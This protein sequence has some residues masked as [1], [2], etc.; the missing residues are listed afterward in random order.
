MGLVFTLC[1]VVVSNRAAGQQSKECPA[2]T[3]YTG[4]TVKSIKVSSPFDFIPAVSHGFGQLAGTLPLKEGSPFNKRAYSEGVGI[5]TTSVLTGYVDGFTAMRFIA[6]VPRL[7]NCTADSVE[8]RY[9][10]YSSVFPPLAGNSFEVRQGEVEKPASTGG[11]LSTRGRFLIVPDGGYNHT[12]RG[13]AGGLIQSETPVSIFDH[14]KVR[15]S[16]SSN[17]LLGSIDLSGKRMLARHY[18]DQAEWHLNSTYRDEPA[19]AFRLKEAKLAASFFGQTKEIAASKPVA[20]YA[21]SLAGGHQQGTSLDSVNSSYGDLKAISGLQWQQGSSALSGSYGLQLG[22]TFNQHSIDFAKHILDLRYSWYFSPLPKYRKP[23]D[24][25]DRPG[26]IGKVHRP[27]SLEGQANAGL[28]QTFGVVPAPERFFGGNQESAPFIENQ[29]WDVRGGPY[30]RSIPEN[31]IGAINPAFGVGGTRFYSLNLTLA[32]AVMG[33]PLLPKE[34]SDQGFVD[35]LDG[36]I[37]TAKLATTNT[38]LAQ[39]PE[40]VKAR[41]VARGAVTALATEV[42][43]LRTALPGFSFGPPVDAKIA[44]TLKDL[45]SKSMSAILITDV[46][47]NGNG[48]RIAYLMDTLTPALLADLD[49]V[50]AALTAP[51]LAATA[52]NVHALRNSLQTALDELRK[53]WVPPGAA[54]RERAKVQANQDMATAEK[55]LNA[56]LYQ[57]NIYSVAPVGVFDVARVWPSGVGVRYGIGGGVRVS[58]VNANFTVG[59]AANPVRSN[60]EGP[61]ALFFKLDVLELFH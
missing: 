2:D 27:F 13:Y 33:K 39:D 14:I 37:A 43:K 24:F 50:E 7:E 6:T 55:V 17:S 8:V 42:G 26:F 22:S 25:D 53:D 19:G 4:R 61:G 16:A 10:V 49:K 1:I 9:V 52:G 51:E 20:H 15:S 31:Q 3:D 48:T 45:K 47:L 29:P 34:L 36:G 5:I 44:G 54:A 60:K 35:A 41:D 57:L 46:V 32:K 38:Y 30:I 18:L 56:L 58:V 21:V 28:I 40:V 23:G 59:Y 12:R 11:S